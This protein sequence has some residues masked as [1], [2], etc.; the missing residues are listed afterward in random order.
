MNG[1]RVLFALMFLVFIRPIFPAENY[2]S[3]RRIEANYIFEMMIDA[4]HS[5][6]ANE[7]SYWLLLPSSSASQQ[8]IQFTSIGPKPEQLIPGFAGE[9]QLAYWHLHDPKQGR[10]FRI[11]IELVADLYRIDYFL[12]PDQ[13]PNA[14]GEMSEDVAQYLNSDSLAY[15]TEQIQQLAQ[16][17]T[18]HTANPLVKGRNIYRWVIDHLEP[19]FPIAHRGT[20]ALFSEK[21]QLAQ[22]TYFGDSAEYTWAFVALC[23]AAGIPARSVTGFLTKAQSELPHTWAEFYLPKWGWLPADPYLADSKELLGE[24]SGQ[25]D[26]FFY[27]GH[28]DHY[29]LAFYKG[30]GFAI[31]PRGNLTHRPFIYQDEVW[32][33]PIGI[34]DFD[35]FTNAG[36]NLMIHWEALLITKYEHPEYGLTI[37]FSSTWQ[38]QRQPLPSHFVVREKFLTLD[39]STTLDLM[40][41]ALPEADSDLDAQKAAKLELEAL[42]RSLSGYQLV[43]EQAVILDGAK[44]YQFIAKFKSETVTKWEYRLYI[45]QPNHLFWL[46]GSS[47]E[48]DIKKGS[49]IFENLIKRIQFRWPE[50]FR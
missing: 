25:A 37:D 42:N 15:V 17:L 35:R 31:E 30:N 8:N 49:R 2:H 46:I 14:Y 16:E 19:Q 41:R 27:F 12:A 7:A 39:K 26:A 23:R 9:S 18:Q 34:W 43:S 29:H 21:R 45:V 44:G 13:V 10:S 50:R 36:A 5:G 40:A 28:L 3:P 20:R 38:H 22:G 4:D 33:A 32:F 6:A 47:S 1:L 48:T 24:F 11:T